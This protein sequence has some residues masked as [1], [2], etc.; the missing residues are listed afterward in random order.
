MAPALALDFP[1]VPDDVAPIV[2]PAPRPQQ[3]KVWTRK[4]STCSAHAPCSDCQAAAARITSRVV[5]EYAPGSLADL[6]SRRT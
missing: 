3:P 2:V 1:D 5:G 6:E 4:V